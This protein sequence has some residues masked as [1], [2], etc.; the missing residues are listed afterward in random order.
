MKKYKKSI[1]DPWDGIKQSNTDMDYI[2]IDKTISQKEKKDQD[3]LKNGKKF[4][5]FDE[6]Y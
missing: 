6:K 4:P 2:Y 1:K 3:I 5:K